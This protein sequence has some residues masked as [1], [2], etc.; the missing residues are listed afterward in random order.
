[1]RRSEWGL[2]RAA[3][4][5]V[6]SLVRGY[7]TRAGGEVEG[8]ALPLDEIVG[9][10]SA[11]GA[12][13]EELRTVL[14][15]DSIGRRARL[16][17]R[18]SDLRVAWAKPAKGAARF[19][20]EDGRFPIRLAKLPPDVVPDQR[21]FIVD[22]D[23]AV[24]LLLGSRLFAV[25][26][27]ATTSRSTS[28]LSRF[29]VTGT[30]ETLPV[31]PGLKLRLDKVGRFGLFMDS[32]RSELTTIAVDI[33]R[34]MEERSS[35]SALEA[36]THPSDPLRHKADARLLKAIGLAANAS[37]IDVL[38]RLVSLNRRGPGTDARIRSSVSFR[39][40]LAHE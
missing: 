34:A 33:A 14:S 22:G 36:E 4:A 38:D 28:W 2:S 37:D 7:L 29:S 20:V 13:A 1:L 39:R 19:V 35:A 12:V 16:L 21:L 25:W 3:S 27:R 11:G 32:G 6:S 15:L 24:P 17:K 5:A 31:P 26:A 18:P 23:A 9:L 8:V 10:V 40:G 30:F